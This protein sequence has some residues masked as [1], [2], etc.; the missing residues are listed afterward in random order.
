MRKHGQN[1]ITVLA[2]LTLL[3]GCMAGSGDGKGPDGDEGKEDRWNSRNDPSRFDGEFNYHLTDLPM[4][5]S[6]EREAW[7]STYWPTYEDSIQARWQSGQLSPAEKYDVA[8]NGWTPAADFM[9][10]R[11]F[12]RDNPVP[13]TGWDAAYYTSLG[14][15]ASYVSQNMGNRA[16][17]DQAVAAMGRP[18]GEWDVETWFGLCHAWVPAALLEDRPLRPVTYNGVT[19]EVGDLEALLIATYNR[20]SADMIGGRCNT[21]SGDTT[22]ERDATGRA[23]DVDCRDTNPGSF[24]VIITNYLGLLNRGFAEDR[25]YDYQVWN[26]PVQGYEITRQEEITVAQAN[27]LLGATGDTYTY[28]ADAAKLYRVHTTLSWVT[29]S[30]ASTTPNDTSRYTRQDRYTYIIEVDAAGKIIGGEWFGSSRT[31]HPDF[32]WN[33][34]RI[35]RSAVPNLSVNDVRMLIAMSRAEPMEPSGGDSLV[36]DGQGGIAIP[37][38]DANGI[39]S[40]ATISG[41]GVIATVGVA[42]DITH[43]YI[44]DLQVVLEHGGNSRTL[45]NREGGSADNIARSFDVVGFEGADPNGDWAL[46]VVDLAGRDVGTLNSWRL[47]LGVTGGTPTPPPPVTG[48]RFAG[49]GGIAIPDNDPNGVTSEANVAGVTAGSVSIEVNIT[50]TYIGDL[51]IKVSHAGRSWTLHDQD[52]GSD[53]DIA[54][55]FPLD[56][57]GNA[58]SGDPSG[59]WT[60]SVSDNAGIDVGTLNSWA[61]LVN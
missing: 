15:L 4:S 38:N 58:F 17:R 31:A 12:D 13:G 16:D 61:V 26:Q 39:V 35:T 5:G 34:R 9:S 55:T 28:N 43:T 47:T 33:P 22:V 23:V 32:L 21:G 11:P 44:G 10:L 6:A 37:D 48:Q 52:G 40:N 60:L 1:I 45:H 2:A 53:A 27:E 50:H 7:P 54:R 18:T 8:F 57:T 49:A 36:A 59:A 41:S 25:T 19:F 56:A 14:P 20:A 29:E 42:V 46:R 30:H 51:V 3:G 24:H